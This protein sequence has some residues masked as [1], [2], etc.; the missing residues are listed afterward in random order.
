MYHLRQSK[1]LEKEEQDNYFNTVI[2]PLFTQDKPEQLLFSFLKEAECIGYGGL[3]HID[4]GKQEAEVSFLIATYLEKDFLKEYMT[5]FFGFIDQ[6]AFVELGLNK[7]YTYAYD[8]RPHIYPIIEAN[9]FLRKEVLPQQI[10]GGEVY[11]NVIIHEKEPVYPRLR[12]ANSTDFEATFKWASSPL[13]R[14]FSFNNG[15]IHFEEHQQWFTQKIWDKNCEYYLLA[16]RN[17][18]LG[19]LRFDI[20]D[21]EVAKIN[22]LIDPACQGNGYGKTILQMGI[23]LLKK[24]RTE[25]KKVYGEVFPKNI[26]CLQIVES[27]GFHITKADKIYWIEKPF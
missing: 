3:V 13:I 19:S 18:F 21:D 1:P 11:T 7:L 8:V 24:R 6:V 25:V 17:N 22:M 5:I 16:D 15:I 26:A 4:W 23:E 9:G 27:L 2:R 14:K 20:E 12:L 10:R